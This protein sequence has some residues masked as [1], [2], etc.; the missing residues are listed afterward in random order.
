MGH[1]P[2]QAG[3]GDPT[4]VRA[5]AA[6]STST[7]EVHAYRGIANAIDNLHLTFG[8]LLIE[9]VEHANASALLELG[10]KMWN[11]GVEF[12]RQ[13]GILGLILW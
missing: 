12:H 10:A 8:A 4:A 7:K 1:L 11:G 3:K 13:L 5:P 9:G 6:A 2:P